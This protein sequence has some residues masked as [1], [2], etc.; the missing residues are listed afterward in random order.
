[1]PQKLKNLIA[2]PFTPMT[3][4]GQV[5]TALIPQYAENLIE[6]GVAGVFISGSTG[7]GI[8]LSF[9]ERKAITEAWCRYGSE[10]FHVMVHV[11]SSNHEESSLLAAHAQ[12]HR[13]SSIACMGPFTFP[14]NRVEE[15]VAYCEKIA[16]A[17]PN[18][19]FYYYHI[20]RISGAHVQMLDVLKEGMHR[21]PNLAGVKFTNTDMIDMQYCL[22]FEQSKFDVLY[23]IDESLLSG[24][25]LGV[26]AAVGT[27]YNFMPSIFLQMIQSFEKG[28]LAKAREYQLQA[29]RVISIMLKNNGPI[30]SGKAIL[31][32]CGLDC[33]PCR[34]PLRNLTPAELSTMK[35]ELEDVGFFDFAIRIV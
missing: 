3:N 14:P 31:G 25:A 22:A 12:Q 30:V 11:G 8:L 24:L 7:E 34:L 2:A 10:N 16:F 32:F 20:P 13:A 23:G 26:K 15:V 4:Q 21:I 27:T 6:N 1:M 18:L 9:A 29:V 35:K 5:V 17:A 28:D 33:G 19:P